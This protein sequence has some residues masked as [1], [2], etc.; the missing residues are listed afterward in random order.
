[1]TLLLVAVVVL[2]AG[3]GLSLAMKDNVHRGLAAVASQAVATGLVLWCVLPVLLGGG[4]LRAS[5][6]WSFPIDVIAVHLDSLG[7][8]FLAWSLPMTLLGTV[9]AT[10]YLRPWFRTRNAGRTWE[11]IDR[12]HLPDVPHQCI[13]IP[14]PQ[15]GHLYVGNEIGVFG[16]PDDGA[17][18][19]DLSR[20][21][22]TTQMVDLVY[23]RRER[24]LSAATYG[25]SIW[26]LALG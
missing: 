18:W 7:A 16:S 4:D 8:F 20:N 11:D 24:T 14:G 22:P 23:Q 2:L 17:T 5:M 15:A 19:Q 9:Y 6:A 21:L 26:R 1:M 3:A 25:R 13:T 10:G 12:G